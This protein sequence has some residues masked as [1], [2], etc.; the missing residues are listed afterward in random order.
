MKAR[1]NCLMRNGG[2]MQGK[3][4]EVQ[5][6]RFNWQRSENTSLRIWCLFCKVLK[7]IEDFERN[8]ELDDYVIPK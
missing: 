2:V 6:N 5:A 8:Y 3:F 1:G 4:E 7:I